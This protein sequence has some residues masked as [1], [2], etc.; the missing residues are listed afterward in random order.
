MSASPPP[1]GKQTGAGGDRRTGAGSDRRSGAGRLKVFVDDSRRRAAALPPA[2]VLARQAADGPTPRPLNL[3]RF[4]L[5]A[6]VKFRA[7]SVEGALGTP[8]AEEAVRQARHYAAGGAAAISVLTCPE[9]FDGDIAY[10]AAVAE[11]VEVP[12]MRK[13]F[14]VEPGQVFEARLAGASGVLLIARI[15]DDITAMLDAAREAGLFV[16]LELFD[17]SDLDDLAPLPTGDPLLVGVNSR[18]LD[19]LNV[20]AD[21]HRLMR[22]R[23]PA[24]FPT[25]AE[26]GLA[27]PDDAARAARDGYELALVGSALMQGGDPTAAVTAMISAGRNARRSA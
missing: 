13:D 16:L 19:T 21:R 18:C 8:S 17:E 27:T 6:E 10:M 24:G 5:I 25:V 11:A 22:P 20:V 23:L 7:P 2:E 15:L 1:E 9:G 14:L 4:D 3:D 26:S 12:V